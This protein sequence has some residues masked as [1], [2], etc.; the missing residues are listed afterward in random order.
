[1]T[2]TSDAP[3]TCPR[4]IFDPKATVSDAEVGFAH[5]PCGKPLYTQ[6]GLNTCWDHKDD[7]PFYAHLA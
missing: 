1:M 4:E 3:K 5:K 6:L 2:K 7:S